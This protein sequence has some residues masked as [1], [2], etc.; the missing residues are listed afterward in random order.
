MHA[1]FISIEHNHVGGE[2]PFLTVPPVRPLTI[3]SPESYDEEMT[4]WAKDM[5]NELCKDKSQAFKTR[6]E[7]EWTI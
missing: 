2:G 1:L 4:S 3:P 5:S 7:I 6:L